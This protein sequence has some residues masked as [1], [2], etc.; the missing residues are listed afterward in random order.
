LAVLNGVLGDYLHESGNPLAIQMS[1]CLDGKPLEIEKRALRASLPRAGGRL[2][3]LIHGSSLNDRSWRRLRH[4]H[5][6]A[7]ARDLRPTTAGPPISST[8]RA[9]A[10]LLERLVAEWRAPLEALAIVGHS[11]GGLVARSACHAGERAGHAWRPKLG[12]LVCLGSPHHGA[13]LERGG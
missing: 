9:C 5:R 13:P 10:A 6:P 3:V 1:L 8:G 11:M 4:D 7:P 2:V 12:K